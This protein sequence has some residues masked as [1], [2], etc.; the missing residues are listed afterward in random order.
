[1]EDMP[2]G[3]LYHFILILINLVECKVPCNVFTKGAE[4]FF[5]YLENFCKSV[6]KVNRGVHRCNFVYTVRCA[7][8]W[9]FFQYMVLPAALCIPAHNWPKTVSM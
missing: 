2:G 6:V 3:M 4:I 7:N 1:M 8:Y 9:A 5:L